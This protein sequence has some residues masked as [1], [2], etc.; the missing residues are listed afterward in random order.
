MTLVVRGVRRS[1][2][3]HV[4]GEWVRRIVGRLDKR[5]VKVLSAQL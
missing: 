4:R 2:N 1:G 3:D 5:G